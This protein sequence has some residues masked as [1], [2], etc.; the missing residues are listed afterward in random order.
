MPTAFWIKRTLLVFFASF[1]IILLAQYL[2]TK[3]PDYALTEAAIWG[4]FTTLVYMF[5][6]WR[7]LRKNPSC[8]I[9]AAE[10]KRSD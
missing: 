10:K 9:A 4:G 6:L 1:A 3:R 7:K 5:V 8:A 2:K